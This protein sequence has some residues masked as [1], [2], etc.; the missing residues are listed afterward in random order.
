M[1]CEGW[2]RVVRCTVRVVCGGVIVSCF[3]IW[4]RCGEKFNPMQ[5]NASGCN[6]NS[7]FNVGILWGLTF[8][9]AYF[10]PYN[11]LS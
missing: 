4:W 11:N 8:E 5:V 3:Q 2:W 7:F 1:W 10:I 9:N 6:R